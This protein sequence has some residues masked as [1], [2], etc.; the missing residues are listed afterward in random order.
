MLLVTLRYN[1]N[2]CPDENIKDEPNK[3]GDRSGMQIVAH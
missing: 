1:I 2:K 3:Q